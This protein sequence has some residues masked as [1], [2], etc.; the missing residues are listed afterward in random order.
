MITVP[1]LAP[2]EMDALKRAAEAAV[3][4]VENNVVV[5]LGS[6]STAAFAVEA[7][8][9]RHP[10]G[11]NHVSQRSSVGRKRNRPRES[12]MRRDDIDFGDHA[13]GYRR[14]FACHGEP[15]RP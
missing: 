10:Q 9:R 14:F 7:L 3:Q 13:V 12:W 1:S 11:V 8:A 4:M 6:G 5:W 15:P 2:L